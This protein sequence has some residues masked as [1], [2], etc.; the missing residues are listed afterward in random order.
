VIERSHAEARSESLAET[1]QQL[2]DTQQQ[3]QDLADKLTST[4]EYVLTLKDEL[5]R[6]IDEVRA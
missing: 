4:E 5:D 6:R 1:H 2:Q 3:L